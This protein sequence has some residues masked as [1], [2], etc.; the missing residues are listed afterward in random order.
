VFFGLWFYLFK[1]YLNLPQEF[2][3]IRPRCVYLDVTQEHLSEEMR[4]ILIAPNINQSTHPVI[5]SLKLDELYANDKSIIIRSNNQVHEISKDLIVSKTT[6]GCFIAVAS[7][8]SP[9]TPVPPSNHS[10]LSPATWPRSSIPVVMS[11]QK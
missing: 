6:C 2:G 9:Q 7:P 4:A 10:G 11:Y 1:L 8:S 5:R 3:G